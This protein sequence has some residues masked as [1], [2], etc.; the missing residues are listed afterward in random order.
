MT[1][2]DSEWRMLPP[3]RGG[4]PTQRK[5]DWSSHI[6]PL[7]NTNTNAG[8]ITNTKTSTSASINIC[9]NTTWNPPKENR[10]TLT[11]PF[12]PRAFLNQWMENRIERGVLVRHLTVFVFAV[13]CFCVWTVE[14]RKRSLDATLD[15]V[16]T[17]SHFH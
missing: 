7:P 10:P 17:H 4:D 3:R 15:C 11:F 9:T 14:Q 16:C 8:T 5:T 6:P 12:F 13:V 2:R 1:R